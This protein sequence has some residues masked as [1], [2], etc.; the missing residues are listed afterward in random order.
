[1]T[2]ANPAAGKRAIPLA[3]ASAP[4]PRWP[5]RAAAG[6][7]ITVSSVARRGGVDRTFST[8]TGTC[9]NGSTSS[10]PSHPQ[11]LQAVPFRHADL[12]I[13]MQPGS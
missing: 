5:K 8:G 7:D 12:D 13:V 9:S 3:A 10:R 4:K 11:P 6:E 2:R 1:M